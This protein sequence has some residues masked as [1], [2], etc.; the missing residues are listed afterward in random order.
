MAGAG[1]LNLAAIKLDIVLG[2]YFLEIPTI[3]KFFSSHQYNFVDRLP[4]LT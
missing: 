4:N 3:Q 1:S 2:Y